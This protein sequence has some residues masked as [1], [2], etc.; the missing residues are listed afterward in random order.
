MNL[1]FNL[2][3][4]SYIKLIN[5][6]KFFYTPKNCFVR[7]CLKWT[8]LFKRYSPFES[9]QQSSHNVGGFIFRFGLEKTLHTCSLISLGLLP[10]WNMMQ[11]L[12]REIFTSQT[13]V[14]WNM[15][16][17]SSHANCLSYCSSEQMPVI[18]TASATA[19][20]TA[21]TIRRSE[22]PLIQTSLKWIP[23]MTDPAQVPGLLSV[24]SVFSFHHQFS[25]ALSAQQDVPFSP[26]NSS[27]VSRRVIIF[28]CGSE[29]TSIPLFFSRFQSFLIFLK[30]TLV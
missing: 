2:F 7:F 23:V 16:L 30:H 20:W 9:P 21:L 6:L 14:F 27:E 26:S 12:A 10:L 24:L 5:H 8:C 11:S 29:K 28:L 13:V 4:P 15:L 18:S 1:L 19:V 25:T 22:F 3:S 17:V